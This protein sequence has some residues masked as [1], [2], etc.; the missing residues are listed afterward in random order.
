MGAVHAEEETTVGAVFHEQLR[1]WG[2]VL[3]A[4]FHLNPHGAGTWNANSGHRRRYDCV[5]R[6]LSHT[7]Y[8]GSAGVNPHVHLD[9]NVIIN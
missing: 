9:I 5:A 2:M 3:S 1:K 4:T 8:V 6:S 7:P